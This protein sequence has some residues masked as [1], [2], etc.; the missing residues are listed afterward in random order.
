MILSMP[1]QAL[2]VD[3]FLRRKQKMWNEDMGQG[4]VLPEVFRYSATRGGDL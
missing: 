1:K 2:L 4:R 3:P